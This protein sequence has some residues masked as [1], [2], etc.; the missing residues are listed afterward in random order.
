[1]T[2]RGRPVGDVDYE[3][4]GHRYAALRRTDPR[5]EARVHAALGESRTVLNV[6]AGTGSYEPS[7]RYVL[8]VEPSAAMR[9]QR[10]ATAAPAVDA[11]A[12]RLPF[13]DG[14]FDAAMAMVTIHQ[15]SDVEQGLREM[16][17]VSRGPVVVLTI[18]APALH[19]FWLADYFPEVIALDQTRFPAIDAVAAVLAH[20]SADVRVEVVPVPADCVDGFG[21]AF[22]ARPEAFLRPEV[23]AATSGFGLTDPAAVQRGV[24][25]LRDDLASGAWDR[26][27]GHVREQAEYAGALRLVTAVA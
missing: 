19:R 24:D 2:T 6:G 9:A 21:E 15:W 5:I 13:D 7:D 8:A 17:R 3:Q 11:T 12:E 14:S 22:Y 25:R 10:P 26:A 4:H 27:H 18:D 23:R 20:G 16:R 1:M